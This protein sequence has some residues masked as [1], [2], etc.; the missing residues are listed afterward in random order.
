MEQLNWRVL[1][2]VLQY[3]NIIFHFQLNII[4]HIFICCLW[5]M[6]SCLRRKLRQNLLD[7][8]RFSEFIFTSSSQQESSLLGSK[9][10]IYCYS[11][12]TYL[13]SNCLNNVTFSRRT[14]SAR[15]GHLL[16]RTNHSQ[17]PSFS[18]NVLCHS[19]TPFFF[20][21]QRVGY[22]RKRS[23]CQWLNEKIHRSDL[24]TS[25]SA[26]APINLYKS[27]SERKEESLVSIILDHSP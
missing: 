22:T 11:F 1:H 7:F 6:W 8:E 19:V 13:Q 5:C 14:I 15:L 10:F 4:S 2:D 3:L 9:S 27:K 26:A 18:A 23:D 24:G 16:S 17:S 12:N 20:L 21:W 25:K